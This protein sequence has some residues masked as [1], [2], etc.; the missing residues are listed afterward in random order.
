MSTAAR[1]TVVKTRTQAVS[2]RPGERSHGC[3]A[4]SWAVI[5]SASA[6]RRST[7]FAVSGDSGRTERRAVAVSGPARG[8]DGGS[9][10]A[11]RPSDEI[12]TVVAPSRASNPIERKRNDRRKETAGRG[13]AKKMDQ[14]RLGS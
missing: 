8:G 6:T 9:W 1:R 5:T 3:A 12:Q 4:P 2:T 10:K 14:E 11:I 13:D 7:S